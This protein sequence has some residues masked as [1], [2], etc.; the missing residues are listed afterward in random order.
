MQQA[1]AILSPPEIEDNENNKL[2]LFDLLASGEGILMAGAGLSACMY[3]PWDQLIQL[4][5]EEAKEVSEEFKPFDDKKDDYL[6][7]CDRIKNCIGP[8]AYYD[9][10][11]KCYSPSVDDY[12]RD[13]HRTLARLLLDGKLKAIT[14]TNYDEIL[15]SALSSY[16]HLSNSTVYI[17][18]TI[19]PAMV[20]DFLRSLN[21]KEIIKRVL[22]F[23]GIYSERGSII[24][25]KSEYEGFYGFNLENPGS[26]LYEA[27]KDPALKEENI[28]Q[29][30]NQH[31]M[32]WPLHRKILWSFFATRRM[33]FMGFSLTDPFFRR[34][35]EHVRND[36]HTN[37]Y[38]NHFLIVRLAN[39]TEKVKALSAAKEFRKKY[40]IV[41]IYFEENDRMTGLED[42]ISQMEGNG[43]A[44][45]F[46]MQ[47]E[48]A[49]KK[50]V[51][52][53]AKGDKRVNKL[54]IDI[55]KKRNAND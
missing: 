7:Y 53:Q 12:Y 49:G 20:F 26:S 33:I 13:F 6:D 8:D 43:A 16:T 11:Y 35:L 28:A 40:G 48:P 32:N 47:T 38:D 18:K 39:A 54:L 27:L 4:M 23:H 50:D 17:N 51:G 9:F 29:L 34:M 41:S 37:G 30:L 19:A 3:P 46:Q 42:F 1:E 36:L 15:D 44:P 21:S 2:K 5:Y 52:L 31:G 14:T 24:L 55:S 22:H 45:S 10:I 25:S